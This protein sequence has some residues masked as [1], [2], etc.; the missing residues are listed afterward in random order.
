MFVKTLPSQWWSKKLTLPFLG[1]PRGQK[2]RISGLFWGSSHLSAS[3]YP[4]TPPNA[5][6]RFIWMFYNIPTNFKPKYW[7]ENFIWEKI[8]ISTRWPSTFQALFL[9]IT[10]QSFRLEAFPRSLE[11]FKPLSGSLTP[12]SGCL[13]PKQ[14]PRTTF[15]QPTL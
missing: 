5:Q 11:H 12:I 13:E 6:K 3:R 14:C 4:P 9:A 1:V 7:Q 2:P 15:S 8:K 10:S